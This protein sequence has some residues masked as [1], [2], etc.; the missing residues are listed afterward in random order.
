MICDTPN[1]PPVSPFLSWKGGKS[2][3]G[4]PSTPGKGAV[5]PLDSPFLI[6]LLVLPGHGGGEDF[7]L[8]QTPAGFHLGMV[9]SG[10]TSS[11]VTSNAMSRTRFSGVFS[12]PTMLLIM[13]GPSSIWTMA[14]A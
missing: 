12:I 8:S 9:T 2:L 13:R 3:G 14:M 11:K 10:R 5:A 1:H 4:T 6:S 7:A